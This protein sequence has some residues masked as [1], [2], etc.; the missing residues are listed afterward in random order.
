M[1][2]DEPRT[3]DPHAD[4]LHTCLRSARVARRIL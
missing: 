1:G 2:A 3:H 4:S